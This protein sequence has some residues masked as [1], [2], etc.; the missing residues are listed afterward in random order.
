IVVFECDGCHLFGS[1]VVA[2]SVFAPVNPVGVQIVFVD[3]QDPSADTGGK[4]IH[5]L[6]RPGRPRL[7]PRTSRRGPGGA[8]GKM[9]RRCNEPSQRAGGHYSGRSQIHERFAI[10]HA[11][12]EI[13]ISGADCSLSFLYK[14]A[15]E[16]D[17]RSTTGWQRN[18]TRTDQRLP[19]TSR[20]G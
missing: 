1:H 12:F 13:P 19:V 5:D 9:C 11:S 16:S 17:A 8:F 3:K 10:A 14:S 18:C 6:H 4:I 7:F 15:T 20:L 2:V